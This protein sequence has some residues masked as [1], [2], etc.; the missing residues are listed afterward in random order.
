[1]RA[2]TR[3]RSEPLTTVWRRVE[4]VALLATIPAF[5]LALLSTHRI[6]FVS[7]YLLAAVAS[8]SVIVDEASLGGRGPSCSRGLAQ[9]QIGLLLTVGLVVSALLPAGG[10]LGVLVI[11]LA[12]ALLIVLRLGESTRPWFWRSE[13]SR[14]VTL[15]MLVLV[16]CGVG[17]WWL[18][19]RA[20]TFGDGFWLAFTT[21]ATVGYGDIVPSTPASKIFAVFVV[22]MGVAV[23]SLVTA[24][25]A[26][27]WVQA[28]EREIEKEILQDLHRQLE[29]MREDL[30]AMRRE[31]GQA[32]DPPAVGSKAPQTGRGP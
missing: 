23:I 12:T 24:A 10:E 32:R 15:A 6:V 7:V 1:M 9:F 2:P 17:F 31:L 30:N 27:T 13:L 18:E 16:L 5:Y 8:G 21:A 20:E 19:P 4:G 22:L 25:I 14:F 11:R 28:E 3:T 26:A 29:A